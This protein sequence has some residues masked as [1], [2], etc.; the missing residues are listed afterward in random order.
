MSS[1]SNTNSYIVPVSSLAPQDRKLC[2]FASVAAE[3]AYEPY[4]RFSVGAAVRTRSGNIYTGS[5]LEN[6]S[7]GV[8][9]CAEVSAI[10]AANSAGDF[11]IEAIAIVGYPT[12]ARSAGKEIV[13]PCGRCRQII[14]EASNVSGDDV[15]VIA[16]N[17]DLTRCRIYSISE[18]LPDG[19]G[20]SNLK[21]DVARYQQNRHPVGGLKVLKTHKP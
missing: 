3:T 17:G 11:D 4:S 1:L 19:F 9:I 21:M 14:F 15:K 8:G 13:T 18:L 6:A 2:E 7:Y 10:A 20:P 16:C 12:E 5:N